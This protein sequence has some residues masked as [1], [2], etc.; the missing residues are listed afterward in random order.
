MACYVA[1]VC[2]T[3]DRVHGWCTLDKEPRML[4][5]Q[6]YARDCRKLLH[7]NLQ[8]WCRG[9]CKIL[10]RCDS[11][12]RRY[13]KR[14][15]FFAYTSRNFA[16]PKPL[17]IQATRNNSVNSPHRNYMETISTVLRSVQRRRRTDD[18]LQ[19]RHNERNGVSNYR[20]LDCLRNRLFRRRPMKTS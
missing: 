10:W 7:V 17:F 8:Q 14:G 3:K 13:R 2:F 11:N 9:M 18:P 1:G 16:V 5:F 12:E 19:W 15:F 20:R 6:W 4:C